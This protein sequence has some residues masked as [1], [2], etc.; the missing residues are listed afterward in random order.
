MQTARHIK[1]RSISTADLMALQK[2][3]RTTFY[4][5]FEQHN[6]AE[7]ME[8]YLRTAFS[9]TQLTKELLDPNSY[10]FFA[11]LNGEVAGYLKVN[12]GDAQTELQDPEAM[13]VERIYVLQKFQR[14]GIGAALFKHA[15]Q[16][17]QVQQK[18]YIW[19][20]VWEH[21]EKATRFYLQH[22]FVA[23]SSHTFTLGKDQQTDIL[24]KYDLQQLKH[25]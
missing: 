21:N 18:Q 20:A 5:T 22:G 19:L 1:I 11:E 6:T 2:I 4:E 15:I 7:D 10:F 16:F 9:E 3:G 17:A 14:H 24:M 23:F 13:E 12:F 25:K 8:L